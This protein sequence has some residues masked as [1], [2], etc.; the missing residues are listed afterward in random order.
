MPPPH[1]NPR[2]PCRQKAHLINSS[3]L[4]DLRKRRHG[5]GRGTWDQ[6]LLQAPVQAQ[7]GASSLENAQYCV[8]PSLSTLLRAGTA[9]PSSVRAGREWEYSISSKGFIEGMQGR[10]RAPWA[11]PLSRHLYLCP[12]FCFLD[13]SSHELRVHLDRQ[14]DGSGVCAGMGHPGRAHGCQAPL[15]TWHLTP[16]RSSR[17]CSGP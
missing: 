10:Q 12:P 5:S 17:V 4:V 8:P 7:A 13:V 3:P 15:S 9:Q 16:P 11:H 14:R 2:V 1:Q 6:T